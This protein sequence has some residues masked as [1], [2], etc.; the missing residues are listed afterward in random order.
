MRTIKILTISLLISACS[1]KIES[2]L[3]EANAAMQQGDYNSAQVI[4]KSVLQQNNE[5]LE[6]RVL[7]A[8]TKFL[9]GA[10]P[11]A[12][13]H[14]EKAYEQGNK[15][16][17]NQLIASAVLNEAYDHAIA[18]Y[19]D[20][21]SLDAMGKAFSLYAA[22][23]Q[24][25]IR[26]IQ[27]ISKEL[28]TGSYSSLSKSFLAAKDGD[29]KQALQHTDNAIFEDS[30]NADAYW[31][32]GIYSHRLYQPNIA[33]AAF[34]KYRELR[35]L[36]PRSIYFLA[37]SAVAANDWDLANE[38][39]RTLTNILENHPYGNYILGVTAL[40]EGRSDE[41]YRNATQATLAN[42]VELQAKLLRGVS[43]YVVGNFESA[44]KD[45]YS[46][47]SQT[48]TTSAGTAFAL[49]SAVE[50]KDAD[51]IERVRLGV[52]RG[53]DTFNIPA[54]VSDIT[55]R[56]ASREDDKYLASIIFDSLVK[57]Y[58]KDFYSVAVQNLISDSL[59]K[60]PSMSL[61]DLLKTDPDNEKILIALM[62]KSL[63]S[64][65]ADV[66]SNY[67][68]L[69]T[70]DSVRGHIEIN[71]AFVEQRY[72]DAFDKALSL[73]KKGLGSNAT[74]N[75]A[76]TASDMMNDKP[77]YF[78]METLASKNELD[79]FPLK[80]LTYL[81]MRDADGSK[82][83]TT[84]LSNQPIV[85][86]VF[87]AERFTRE[88]AFS[89]AL[90]IIPANYTHSEQDPVTKLNIASLLAVGELQQLIDFF[91][92]WQS[93]TDSDAPT[94]SVVRL[95]LGEREFSKV[96]SIVEPLYE[97]KTATEMMQRALARSYVFM[98]DN[99]KAEDVLASITATNPFDGELIY[100]LSRLEE[101]KGNVSKQRELLK[102][103]YGISKS[104]KIV[105]NYAYHYL[106]HSMIEEASTLLKNHTAE[107]P[108]HKNA[109]LLYAM[110][111]VENE[112]KKA[113]KSYLAV[114]ANILNKSPD[115]LNNV[116]FLLAEEG[117]YEKAKT[118]IDLALKLSPRN[119][120]YLDTK[121]RIMRALD[122]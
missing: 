46:V 2:Q 28:S 107:Y 38:Y 112:P 30:K 49:L 39:G 13:S 60:S 51:A 70:D 33:L 59:N 56:L 122:K 29:I 16:V 100:E 47:A 3:D 91:A 58:P 14:F 103:A 42:D 87:F 69:L 95:L 121:E 25:D 7:L 48:S 23:I 77:D 44:F 37:R 57:L 83:L 92:M 76:I 79:I 113:L 73:I 119:E 64:G 65:E 26:T 53:V 5:N 108:E 12:Q 8:Q 18:L 36:D 9:E 93:D 117:K 99:G 97:N 43:A 41:A 55:Y 10:F 88:G 98:G 86:K 90:N 68:G 109:L 31:F 101:S 4:A 1:P 105:I 6:A 17:I 24:N 89:E 72:N 63:K 78:A 66:A 19:A 35:P 22:L 96:I 54:I 50:L 110:V 106:K 81:E 118:Y 71:I 94:E 80:V 15:N 21:D 52:F 120:A 102:K 34:Q 62:Y 11:D 45:L 74:L 27:K 116:A 67:V 40:K 61:E 111:S 115:S 20:N 75:L 84:N 82:W 114:P 104:E 32:K 85:N